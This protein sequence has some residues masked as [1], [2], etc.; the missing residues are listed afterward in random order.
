MILFKKSFVD[1]TLLKLL[2]CVFIA[3]YLIDFI[4]SALYYYFNNPETFA[5]I[6]FKTLIIKYLI[7]YGLK[8]LFILL[9]IKLTVSLITLKKK[10][11]QSFIIH[12]FLAFILSFYTASNTMLMERY[13]F[14]GTV[15]ITL[16][17]VWVRGLG[18]LNYNF[19]VYLSLMAIVYAYYYLKEQQK[20]IV[21]QERLKT[22][23]LDTKINAL[24]SQLQP[25]FLFNALND[26]SSLTDIDVKKSQ[27]AIADLS[28]LLRSTLNIKD[29][30]FITLEEELSILN[31]YLDIEKI[32]FDEKLNINLT[33]NKRQLNINVPP[34]LLQPI[35]ENAIKH[36]FSYNHDKLDISLM[37]SSSDEKIIFEVINN[38]QSLKEE[39][40][41]GN[42]IRNVLERL[43]TLYDGNYT[44]EMKNIKNP[45][46][47]SA[48]V[49]TKII[50][51][52]R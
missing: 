11:F 37:V 43:E 50:I 51:P 18:N 4:G 47:K 45:K 29:Q 10:L 23:L 24:Q 12:T 25:H 3:A 49:K 27:N 35:I 1:K 34:L 31:K 46:S 36:G 21:N 22:Q 8:F 5:K 40:V 15:D 17:S 14:G 48:L 39:I 28:S 19:F 38:G 30:K 33:I 13:L 42:G 9:S 32:R 52:K 26:I 2:L 6:N 20:T 44:F 7:N 16:E 41:Y